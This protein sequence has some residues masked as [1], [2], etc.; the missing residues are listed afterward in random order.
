VLEVVRPD[1]RDL[2]DPDL[3]SATAHLEGCPACQSV[4]NEQRRFDREFA[5]VCRDVAI[6]AGLA[7]RL[8]DTLNITAPAPALTTEG[9]EVL[10]EAPRPAAAPSPNRRAKKIRRVGAG[11][12]AVAACVIAGFGLWLAFGPAALPQVEIAKLLKQVTDPN[13]SALAAPAAPE[14]PGSALPAPQQMFSPRSLQQAVP[15]SLIEA[16]GT[17]VIGA[18]Y[19]FSLQQ[20]GGPALAALLVV[21]DRQKTV[22]QGPPLAD[23]FVAAPIQYVNKI[24]VKVWG[25]ADAV[26]VVFVQTPGPNAL[27]Q[28]RPQL[29]AT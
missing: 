18:V 5:C 20:R 4:W 8:R 12:A 26:Y 22:V 16:G 1:S 3:A 27:E 23:S 14:N 6:P 9:P 29:H 2:A 7:D 28:L 19:Q 24:A 10:S 11:L 21:L 15:R 17:R 25:N 13:F